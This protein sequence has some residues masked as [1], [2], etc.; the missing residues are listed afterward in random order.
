MGKNFWIVLTVSVLLLVG[1]FVIASKQEKANQSGNTSAFQE[2]VNEPLVIRENDHKKGAEQ[3]K[4]TLIEF[5]DF[6]CSACASFFPLLKQLEQDF[7]QDLQFIFRHFPLP[8][9]QNAMSAHRA[10]EAAAK[11]G[12]FFEMHDLLYENQQQWAG[13]NSTQTIF[14][15][16][17]KQL[18]LDEERFKQELSNEDAYN[19][20]NAQKKG[21]QKLGVSGTPT[22]FINGEQ[23][24]NDQIK[25]YEDFKKLIEDKIPKQ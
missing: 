6:E 5:G 21:G 15:S 7:P 23:I 14:E 25:S 9:H 17:A 24:K 4:V 22:F 3:P 2:F 8:G 19:F 1:V 13:S 18:G 12:K 11:Q 20:I 10:S 16:F